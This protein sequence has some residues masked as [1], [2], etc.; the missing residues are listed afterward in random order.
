MVHFVWNYMVHSNPA[1][2][3]WTI[4]IVVMVVQGGKHSLPDIA[5]LQ[6][7]DCQ[8]L[9]VHRLQVQ[10]GVDNSLKRLV[11][12]QPGPNR[13]KYNDINFV[14]PSWLEIDFNSI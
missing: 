4:L 2:V 6:M 8:L 3:E 13:R 9:V 5:A 10:H 1:G 14:P 11:V 12:V 7:F